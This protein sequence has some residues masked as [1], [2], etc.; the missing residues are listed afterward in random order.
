MDN[1]ELWT[2]LGMDLEKHDEFLAPIPSILKNLFW[3]RPNRP[4]AMGYFDAVVGDVHGIRV[5]EL[6]AMKEAGAKVFST[7]CVYVPEEIVVATGS[8][9]LYTSDA[10]DEEDSV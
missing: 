2:A 10:A 6:Y 4:K 9:L 3:D 1:R 5:H 8:C 7:F